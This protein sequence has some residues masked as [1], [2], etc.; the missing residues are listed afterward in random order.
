MGIATDL[1]SLQFYP[2]FTGNNSAFKEFAYTGR[3]FGAE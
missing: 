2:K 1:G 3:N